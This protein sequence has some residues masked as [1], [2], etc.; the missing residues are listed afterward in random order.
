MRLSTHDR[1]FEDIHPLVSYEYFH[2]GRFADDACPWFLI[3][4]HYLV[5]HRRDAEAPQFLVI[6][7]RYID[8]LPQT[9]ARKLRCK[10][11]ADRNETLHVH[12]AAAEQPVVYAGQSE[13]LVVPDLIVNRYRIRVSGQDDAGPATRTA[14]C[15]KIGLVVSRIRNDIAVDLMG[16]Q[17]RAN[18][19]DEF[20]VAVAAGGIE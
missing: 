8:R 14:L 4:G 5:D 10:R 7:H 18:E 9:H 17:I 11:D 6:G 3:E 19:L 15:Q 20:Q 12:R 13:W 1:R 2:L 16:L